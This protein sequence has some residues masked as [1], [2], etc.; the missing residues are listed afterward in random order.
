M[1]MTYSPSLCPSCASKVHAV[2]RRT[3]RRIV[4]LVA[5]AVVLAACGGGE[6]YQ[7]GATAPT[8]TAAAATTTTA[9]NVAAD[10]AG[11]AALLLKP[12]D[13]P[14]WKATPDQKDPA[15]KAF[16]DQLAACV[17]RPSPTT[18]TTASADSPNFSMGNAEVSSQ[19]QFVRTVE[20]FKA[21]VAAVRG[22]KY[23][24]CV[25]NGLA[26][27]LPRQLPPGASLQSIAV[28]PLPIA[29]Y[30]EF[31][32]RFRAT[33]TLLIQGQPV[34]VYQDAILL[35]KGRVELTASF[36]NMGQPFDPALAQA[37]VTKLSTRLEAA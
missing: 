21:D 22:P 10:R 15:D 28:K 16:D 23:A 13:L 9:V 29:G 34:S 18:Y 35:G 25:R 3:V 31:S 4:V 11:A 24:P 20:D 33:I 7:P 12:S 2:R 17:G 30:G 6:E 26:R 32:A 37:L 1:A 19:A 5:S 36:S 8:A 27:F 14:G